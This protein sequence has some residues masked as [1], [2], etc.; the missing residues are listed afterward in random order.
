MKILAV[1]GRSGFLSEIIK[2]LF[3]IAFYYLIS[4]KNNS[5]IPDDYIGPHKDNCNVII[6][7][8]TIDEMKHLT[9]YPEFIKEK[10]ENIS[11]HIEHFIRYQ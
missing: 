1:S 4:L 9:I 11:E 7:W 3:N 8:V 10:I 2:Y 5:D 6:E